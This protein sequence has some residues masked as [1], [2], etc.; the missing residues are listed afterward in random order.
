MHGFRVHHFLIQVFIFPPPAEKQNPLIHV[1]GKLSPF[2][3]KGCVADI[4][5]L[6]ESSDMS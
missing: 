2:F 6:L 3:I 1:P 4:E 5:M